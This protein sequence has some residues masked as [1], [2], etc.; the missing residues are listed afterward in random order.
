MQVTVRKYLEDP[1][2]GNHIFCSKY[3]E[4]CCTCPTAAVMAQSLAA[5]STIREWRAFTSSIAVYISCLVQTLLQLL[6][7]ISVRLLSSTGTGTSTSNGTSTRQLPVTVQ[8]PVPVPVPDSYRYRGLTACRL[9][10][11][12]VF[13]CHSVTTER[14]CALLSV[15]HTTSQVALLALSYCLTV[16]FKHHTSCLSTNVAWT[17]STHLLTKTLSV[18]NFPCS[19][20]LSFGVFNFKSSYQRCVSKTHSN[21]IWPVNGQLECNNCTL[22]LCISATAK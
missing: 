20:R 21:R 13:P 17:Q 1:W 14:C 4:L 5:V 10:V 8:I 19:V 12:C 9:F 15:A 7:R 22:Q 11:M 16:T 2:L 6:K 18:P 3:C